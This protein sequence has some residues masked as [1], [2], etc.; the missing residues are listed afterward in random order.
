MPKRVPKGPAGGLRRIGTTDIGAH[1]DFKHHALLR[2]RLAAAVFRVK[3][4]Q[5]T[6]VRMRPFTFLHPLGARL[7]PSIFERFGTIN[8]K[9]AGPGGPCSGLPYESHR[10]KSFGPEGI[11]VG[12]YSNGPRHGT[13]CACADGGFCDDVGAGHVPWRKQHSV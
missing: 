7:I 8:R 1:A 5:A 12:G 6:V 10:L 4:T 13:P 11:P 2:H 3:I 9:A